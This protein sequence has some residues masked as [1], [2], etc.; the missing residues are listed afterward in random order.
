MR[1]ILALR[2]FFA[3]LLGRALPSALLPAP[4]EAPALAAPEVEPPRVE[5]PR[6]EPP[7]VEPPRVEPPR[8]EPEAV[9]AATLGLLQREGR[10]LDFLLGEELDGYADA[11]IG[12]VVR[13]LHRDCRKALRD[14]FDLAPVR[15]ED[16]DARVVV[17]AGFDP[18]EVRLVGNVVGAPPFSGTLKHR[19]WRLAAARL[20][21]IAE[22]PAARVVAPAE[23]EL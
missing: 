4:A 1:L 14:H 7:R 12:A 15:A 3:V 5:P 8:V 18:A 9:A 19:G 22:G 21:R 13:E 20:P 10:L 23:V 2:A 6:V 11:D 17:A 16:E